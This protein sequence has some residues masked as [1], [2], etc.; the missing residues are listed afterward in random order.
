[1]SPFPD[2]DSPVLF[3]YDFQSWFP[4]WK[5]SVGF[6]YM[7]TIRYIRSME[8]DTRLPNNWS[9][10]SY[11]SYESSS[12]CGQTQLGQTQFMDPAVPCDP[13]VSIHKVHDSCNLPME[14]LRRISWDGDGW[15][16]KVK[17]RGVGVLKP[18]NS[19]TELLCIFTHFMT[20]QTIFVAHSSFTIQWFN[21]SMIQWTSKYPMCSAVK[22]CV[23]LFL[24]FILSSF[25]QY[26]FWALGPNCRVRFFGGNIKGE[27]LPNR[28][29]EWFGR[30]NLR[31][32]EMMIPK[33]KLCSFFLARCS[34]MSI[35]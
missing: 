15:L 28:D 21:D 7:S 22:V 30:V 33:F 18:F 35:V 2:G 13:A 25:Y 31:E 17:L 20:A 11:W 27:P 19:S 16:M 29:S 5:G 26:F 6:R 10:G 8:K 12:Q 3:F 24:S 23:S 14:K 9:Y 32:I 34:F 1:M 4:F